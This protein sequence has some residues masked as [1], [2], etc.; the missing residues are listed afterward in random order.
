[1][2]TTLKV[3]NV[4]IAPIRNH[5]RSARIT[6]KEVVANKLPAFSFISLEVTIGGRIHKIN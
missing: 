5:R 1:M 3:P 6:A 4:I 2:A